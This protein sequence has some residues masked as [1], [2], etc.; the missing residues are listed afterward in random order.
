MIKHL[1]LCI[2]PYLLLYFFNHVNN[3]SSDQFCFCVLLSLFVMWLGRASASVMSP[4]F[5]Y[6][7]KMVVVGASWLLL[8][9][10]FN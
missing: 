6:S 3:L 10:P 7:V 5:S 9:P 8:G 4:T 1:I 2:S